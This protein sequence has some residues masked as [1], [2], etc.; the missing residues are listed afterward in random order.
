MKL[1]FMIPVL[2]TSLVVAIWSFF[3]MSE[4]ALINRDYQTEYRDARKARVNAAENFI[5]GVPFNNESPSSV[6]AVNDLEKAL[7]RINASGGIMGKPAV[8]RKEGNVRSTLSY[9][10]Y[11]EEVCAP[12]DTAVCIGPFDTRHLVS[13]RAITHEKAVP[14]I[15]PAA[16][17]INGIPPLGNDN[18]VGFYPELRYFTDAVYGDIIR[19]NIRSILFI[20]PDRDSYGDLFCTDIESRFKG[21][22]FSGIYRVNYL[23][24]LRESPGVL[25]DTYL[26]NP[27]LE[28]IIFAGV[29]RDIRNLADILK[30]YRLRIP[31]YTT[32]VISVKTAAVYQGIQWQ[33]PVLEIEGRELN[34]TGVPEQGMNS[35]Y[36]IPELILNTLKRVLERSE[37]D[38]ATLPADLRLE[39]RKINENIDSRMSIR[40]E[41]ISGENADD[42]N[43]TPET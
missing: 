32:N 23:F 6:Q 1:P 3:A 42:A 18:F 17:K 34:I 30:G 39:I 7:Y 35:S 15:S 8:L 5:I 38:P 20:C 25:L 19:R 33:I 26:R 40:L 37:Y 13:G 43:S 41:S 9:Y 12:F 22:S 28:A 31:V 2:Y 16:E 11:L 27:E 14:Y 4:Y 29:N 24:P 10:G 36:T 21:Q